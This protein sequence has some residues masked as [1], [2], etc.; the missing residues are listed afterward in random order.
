[1]SNPYFNPRMSMHHHVL[2]SKSVEFW[3]WIWNKSHRN[4]CTTELSCY[5]KF[6]FWV[7]NFLFWWPTYVL[8]LPLYNVA[9]A[10]GFQSQGA[11][12]EALVG[13][14]ESMTTQDLK[15][16]SLPRCVKDKQHWNLLCTYCDGDDLAATLRPGNVHSANENF[17]LITNH[18]RILQ[19][20]QAVLVA[21]KEDKSDETF[22]FYVCETLLVYTHNFGPCVLLSE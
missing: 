4:R 2:F 10:R 16:S 13:Y 8:T 7:P 6:A 14:R 21:G 3:N 17:E 11:K 1:M 12:G 22:I 15:S 19:E 20:L 18:Q 5:P 9:K